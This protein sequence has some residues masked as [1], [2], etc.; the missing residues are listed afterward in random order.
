MGRKLSAEHLSR[1]G[2]LQVT[3]DSKKKTKNEAGS[4]HQFSRGSS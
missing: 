1:S 4:F 3:S 2:T